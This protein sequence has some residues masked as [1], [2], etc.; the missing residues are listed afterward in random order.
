VA[1]NSK[2]KARP[3]ALKVVATMRAFRYR[4]ELSN[5]QVAHLADLP[6]STA[7]RLLG[8]LV[9]GGILER[10]ARGQYRVGPMLLAVAANGLAA[11][12]PLER[13]SMAANAPPGQRRCAWTGGV[14]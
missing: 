13:R 11:T 8:E 14:M 3:V 4:D 2:T 9:L 12:D 10:T 6:A 1:G 7:H 5:V